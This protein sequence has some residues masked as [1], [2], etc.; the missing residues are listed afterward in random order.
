MAGPSWQLLETPGGQF[1]HPDQLPRADGAWLAAPVPGT[2]CEALSQA[3]RLDLLAPRSLM[4]HDLWYRSA[5]NLPAAATLHFEGL[6]GVVEVWLDGQLLCTHRHMHLPLSL[7]LPAGAFSLFLCFRALARGGLKR[8]GRARWRPRMIQ[9]PSL[10]DM[11]QT[12]LGHMVG[13]CPEWTPI[14]PFGEIRLTSPSDGEPV[15]IEAMRADWTGQGAWLQLGLRGAQWSEGAQIR[16]AGTCLPLR[17]RD[18]G[19]WWAEG[20]LP[21][22]QAWAPHTH[23]RPELHDLWLDAGPQQTL[24]ARVGFRSIELDRQQGAFRLLI[25]GQPV[26]CRG[27]CWTPPD[28]LRLSSQPEVYRA[29]AR[30]LVNAGMNM[31]RVSGTM[32]YEQAAFF[33]ACD[34]A[35]LLVWHDFML[36]NFDYPSRDAGFLA[37]LDAEARH[38]L[39]RTL[40]HPC[41]AVLCGGSEVRQ[42]AEMLGVD[43]PEDDPIFQ[44]LLARACAEA[45]P[46]VPYVPN[47]PWGGQPSFSTDQGVCHYY[48]VGAYQRGLDDARRARVRFASECMA[49]AHVPAEADLAPALA[50]QPMGLLWKQGTPRDAAASWDFDD[51]R[52]HYLQH[53][54]GVDPGRLRREDP[55]R[56]LDLGRAV[57]CDLA[58]H[59]F[60]EW[61]RPDSGCAGA[62]VWQLRDLREGAGWGL[63]DHQARP[64]PV[65]HALTRVL[66]PVQVLITDEGL[67]CLALHVINERPQV[68][69]AVLS[70]QVLREGQRLV[71]D[72]QQTLELPA[73]GAVTLSST[74]LL[75]RFFDISYAYRF[76]PPAHDVSVAVLRDALTA[77]VL[78]WACHLPQRALPAADVGFSTRLQWRDGA[79]QL[80][81]TVQR[82]AHHVHFVSHSHQP[83]DDWFHLP[84][85]IEKWL[86]LR[87]REGAAVE[88]ALAGGTLAA[89]NGLTAPWVRLAQPQA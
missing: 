4:E 22:A 6:A 18:D 72:G 65:W 36:A 7:A 63:L 85:G 71:I 39:G 20:G 69:K 28:L 48:G 81:I 56:Y 79:W 47:T 82:F 77:Q 70:L 66:Q 67:N 76:G 3:G 50:Q 87:P 44:G 46:D 13:W 54:Y 58:E 16:C 75:G 19:L 53:P 61:R 5:W 24:L 1:D 37:E 55:A 62:L 33:A 14:G 57:S 88:P 42:Q 80:G 34:E 21:Q 86:S 10:R 30:E 12:V 68:L 59:L 78:G 38:F 32:L 15:R 43:W 83:S 73:H 29:L 27:V 26:F 41:V 60:S 64:K 25:N 49:L 89:L 52:E 51:V 84:P 45:R 23:G 8:Q 11:R 2:A 35:G 74:D 17:Q 9:P 40:C 31:V